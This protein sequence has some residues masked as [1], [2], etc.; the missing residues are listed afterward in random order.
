MVFWKSLYLGLIYITQTFSCIDNYT[1]CSLWANHNLCDHYFIK[2]NC[3]I[4]CENSPKIIN[5]CEN[6]YDNCNYWADTNECYENPEFMNNYCCRTCLN[7]FHIELE[8]VDFALIKSDNMTTLNTTIDKDP[9]SIIQIFNKTYITIINPTPE[10]KAL[11]STI[12]IEISAV[13][14]VLSFMMAITALII[15][16]INNRRTKVIQRT[17]QLNS[18][19]IIPSG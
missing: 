1:R 15:N 2:A 8:T 14:G 12:F 16:I 5:T 17:T 7:L 3:C 18:T 13:L 11:Y 9:L 10:R 6:K 19:R 4:S